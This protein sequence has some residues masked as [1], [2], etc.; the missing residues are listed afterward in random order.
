MVRIAAY[1]SFHRH[2]EGCAQAEFSAAT[3]LDRTDEIGTQPDPH[4]GLLGDSERFRHLLACALG[5]V[6]G[7]LGETGAGGFVQQL[8]ELQEGRS[9]TEGFAYVVSQLVRVARHH[10]VGLVAAV[11]AD[12][13]LNR[14]ARQDARPSDLALRD[15][16]DETAVDP[17]GVANG[18]EAGVERRAGGGEDGRRDLGGAYLKRACGWIGLDRPRRT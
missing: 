17:A 11:P 2:L 12:L 9:A 15:G 3:V 8:L 4:S 16:G 1:E 6:A 10:G 5:P 13:A 7:R 18:G 14:C